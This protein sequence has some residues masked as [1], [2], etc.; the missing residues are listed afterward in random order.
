VLV[1]CF[2]DEWTSNTIGGLHGVGVGVTLHVKFLW[3]GSDIL[4]CGK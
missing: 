2:L 1:E 4:C 3:A